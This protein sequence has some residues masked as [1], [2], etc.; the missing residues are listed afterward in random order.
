V[1]GQLHS[2][3]DNIPW[4]IIGHGIMQCSIATSCQLQSEVLCDAS[5]TTP[6]PLPW[7]PPGPLLLLLLL[8]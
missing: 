8:L 1:G 5:L 6:H 7:F 2:K 4:L 3:V